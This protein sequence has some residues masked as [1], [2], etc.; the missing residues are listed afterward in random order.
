MLDIYPVCNDHSIGF[1]QAAVYP[2]T[3][4]DIDTTDLVDPDTQQWH[5][6]QWK[7]VVNVLSVAV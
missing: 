7:A 2:Y 5:V 6:L 3:R 1:M 4:R